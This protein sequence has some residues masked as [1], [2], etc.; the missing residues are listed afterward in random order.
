MAVRIEEW[1]EAEMELG[2]IDPEF[3]HLPMAWRVSAI[4][5]ILTGKI[6]DHVDLKDAEG[7]LDMET[8]IKEV[9]KYAGVK[10]LELR[11]T[12]KKKAR[13][14]DA[15]DVDPILGWNN[16]QEQGDGEGEEGGV[17]QL[18]KGKG[19]ESIFYGTCNNCGIVGQCEN[20]QN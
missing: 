10:R 1:L 18:Y 15:M 12:G 7:E 2:R 6:K 4:R 8:L 13:G 11:D 9:R 17:D 14:P 5:G 20:A 3:E 16:N 19:G